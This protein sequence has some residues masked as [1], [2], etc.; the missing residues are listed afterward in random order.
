VRPREKCGVFGAHSAGQEIFS[1]L[2]WGMLAQN[3]RGHHSYG[4]ATCSGGIEAYTHLGLIPTDR[5]PGE[6]SPVRV[7][8]GRVG[9]ANVRYA[10]SG[11]SEEESLRC[12][13][14]PIHVQGESRGVA[15]SFNGN[16]VNVREL[17]DR[18]GADRG[19]SDTHALAQLFLQTLE[20]GGGLKDAARACMEGIDGSYSIV[21]VTDDGTLFAFKDP[22]GVKPLCYGVSGGVHA[23]SSES[24]G[25][26]IN[27]LDR[28]REFTPGEL[29]TVNDSGVTR[30]QVV[31]WRRQAFCAFEFA[32]FARPDSRFNGKYVYQARMDFGKA[33]ARGFKDN[34]N[35]CDVCIGIPETANDAAYGFH[36]ESGL[37]WDMATRRHRFVTQRAFISKAGERADV[38]RRKVNLLKDRVEGRCLAV[39]DDSIV[40]GDTTKGTV[41]RL[42][43]AGANEVHLFITF[44]RIIGPCFYGIDMATYGELIGAAMSPE[45]IAEE[46]GADSVNY[47]SVDEYVRETGMPR[48]KLCLGCV[49]GEYPTPLANRLSRGM[50]ERLRR[51]DAEKGRIYE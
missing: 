4:F 49:T 38:I 25:L 48:S 46:V 21:G 28:V 43:D 18:V 5:A 32:Y 40:R 27:G 16:I 44:P 15:I 2:Y 34:V 7:M 24:V 19:T 14:M 30:E 42:R 31:P 20:G 47:L 17:Q 13:A 51:G 36:E 50:R 29:M 33:L 41:K 23:F 11:S 3:H 1:F 9:V 8:P 39:V 26:D 35:R 10:T 37:P 12:D 22:V 6:D 45:E